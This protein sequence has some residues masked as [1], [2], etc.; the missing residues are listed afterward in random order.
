VSN[1]INAGDSMTAG[2]PSTTE[3]N[4]VDPEE[5]ERLFREQ[6]DRLRANQEPHAAQFEKDREAHAA[7]FE[8]TIAQIEKNLAATAASQERA[9]ALLGMPSPG[10]PSTEINDPPAGDS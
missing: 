5:S 9:R 1:S 7:R 2:W 4:V 10:N 8:E 3:V 6:M